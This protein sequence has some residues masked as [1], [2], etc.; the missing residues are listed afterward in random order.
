MAK[1]KDPWNCR[2]AKSEVMGAYLVALGVGAGTVSATI[3]FEPG[4]VHAIRKA[5]REHKGKPGDWKGQKPFILDLVRRVG[6]GAAQRA[7]SQ[8]L[9]AVAYDHLKEA[10]DE[11]RNQFCPIR[12]EKG[13][14]IRARGVFC[15][16]M[17]RADH[18]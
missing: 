8:G 11:V 16:D 4:A 7:L 1:R 14:Q 9:G 2:T 17:K 5:L 15:K 12:T 10:Y 13:K 3:G 6:T 18:D